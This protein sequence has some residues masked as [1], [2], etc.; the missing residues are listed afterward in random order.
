MGCAGWDTDGI[1]S[2]HSEFIAAQ[3]H[4]AAAGGKVIDLFAKMVAVHQGGTAGGDQGLGQALLAVAVD[5]GMQQFAND[6]TVLGDE[7]S[8]VVVGGV[9][10]LGHGH[11]LKVSIT[12]PVNHTLHG[13]ASPVLERVS[14]L[15][16]KSRIR[17]K[18][19]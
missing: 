5:G 1:A 12:T 15:F 13:K 3:A 6:R 7:R 8:N 17:D 9:Y 11:L 16:L 19:R 10:T 2:G 4:K 18:N 14:N